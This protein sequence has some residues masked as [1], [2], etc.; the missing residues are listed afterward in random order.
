MNICTWVSCLGYTSGDDKYCDYSNLFEAG[1][2][3]N[4]SVPTRLWW[5]LVD[6]ISPVSDNAFDNKHHT[7]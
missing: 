2:N 1:L 5:M 7:F 4:F 3:H 6:F